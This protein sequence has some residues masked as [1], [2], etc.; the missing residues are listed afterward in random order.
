MTRAEKEQLV[1]EMT[2]A[3]TDTAAIIVCDYEGLTVGELESVRKMA[4][5]NEA[6]VKLSKTHS[7]RLHWQMPGRKLSSLLTPILLSGAM[8]RLQHV[9]LQTNLQQISKINL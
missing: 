7:L 5:E 6:Q 2:E 1:A 4:R 8:I 3:F 9:K